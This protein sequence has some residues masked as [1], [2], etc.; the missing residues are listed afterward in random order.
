G[1]EGVEFAG[2]F[3]HSAQDVK[4][5]LELHHLTAVSSH[6]SIESLRDDPF[7]VIS[8]HQ[9]LGCKFIAIPYLNQEERPGT[10]GFAELIASIYFIGNLCKKAG[11]QL[12]YHNHDFEFEP[13][14]GGYGLDFL[15]SAV[16]ADI[17]QT[18]IDTCWVKYAGLDP[19]EYLLKYMD[20]ATLV[21]IK[22]FVGYKGEK[23][24]TH[25]IKQQ[26]DPEADIAEFS[27]RPLG[28]GIQDLPSIIHSAIQVGAIWLIIEQDDSPDRPPLEASAISIKTLKKY[29]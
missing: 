18:E 19:A 24:P 12:L 10:Q 11:I 28:Y 17:L 7:G 27:Y 15:Y 8:Y 4:E 26:K 14:S 22:D 20:R 23:P 6:V 25:L 2:F 13:F 1:Y 3:G 21:H 9:K 29:Q 5:M 16:P